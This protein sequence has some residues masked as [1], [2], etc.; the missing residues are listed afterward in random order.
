MTSC[1]IDHFAPAYH[2]LQHTCVS[3]CQA[4]E[5]DRGASSILPAPLCQPHFAG[6]NLQA[7][8]MQALEGCNS[9][10]GSLP[11]HSHAIYLLALCNVGSAVQCGGDRGPARLHWPQHGQCSQQ[12]EGALHRCAGL[13]SGF[14]PGGSQV[15]LCMRYKNET[16]NSLQKCQ[17][18]L[19]C[20]CSPP[21]TAIRDVCLIATPARSVSKRWLVLPCKLHPYNDKPTSHAM[22]APWVKHG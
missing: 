18:H 1:P 20:M 9:D 6:R 15:G 2:E 16:R 13:C 19:L 12:D 22:S 3:V 8:S 7:N 4:R 21:W 5:V 10:V 17:L 14:C 11:V